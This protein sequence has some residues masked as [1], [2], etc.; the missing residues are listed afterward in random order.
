[1]T[2]ELLVASVRYDARNINH[3][4]FDRDGRRIVGLVVKSIPWKANQGVESRDEYTPTIW[5]AETGMELFKGKTFVAPVGAG[6]LNVPQLTVSGAGAV[7]VAS[8]APDILEVSAHQQK[9]YWQIEEL[10]S[11]RPLFAFPRRSGR[12]FQFGPGARL[13]AF[14]ENGPSGKAIEIWDLVRHE[15][16]WTIP[17]SDNPHQSTHGVFSPDGN[18]LFTFDGGNV[19]IADTRE[20]RRSVSVS[21]WDIPGKKKVCSF[22]PPAEALTVWP[23][24]IDREGSRVLCGVTVWN[25]TTGRAL[26]HVSDDKFSIGPRSQFRRG[27]NADFIDELLAETP[28][29]PSVIWKPKRQISSMISEAH[30]LLDEVSGRYDPAKAVELAKEAFQA[31]PANDRVV[32]VYGEALL[33]AGRA[34][35]AIPRLEQALRMK[36]SR[37]PNKDHGFVTCFLLAMANQEIG[38][39]PVAKAR[40]AEGVARIARVSALLEAIPGYGKSPDDPLPE[41]P[42]ELL[43]KAARKLGVEMPSLDIGSISRRS[44]VELRMCLAFRA[45]R[46]VQD[47]RT[48]EG[49]ALIEEALAGDSVSIEL[50]YQAACVFAVAIPKTKADPAT[51]SR[52]GDR[53][54][55]LLKQAVALGWDEVEHMKADTDLIPLRGRDDFKKLIAEL[56]KPPAPMGEVAPPP[57]EVK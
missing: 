55:A 45:W 3:L 52:H 43:A 35:E 2:G 5:D 4:R 37:W 30:S 20:T 15:I 16:V 1:M 28:Q 13:G 22:N 19:G 53:A 11:G 9:G 32:S 31:Y 36:D 26:V 12:V 27:L 46:Y 29:Q 7:L 47:G 8:F 49:I 38:R 24:P 25:A 17:G 10:G 56:E 33:R 50:A 41:L 39:G 48:A 40:F 14:F 42:R 34:G 21:V 51:Q 18:R 44:D 6:S 54:I 57:R 23:R